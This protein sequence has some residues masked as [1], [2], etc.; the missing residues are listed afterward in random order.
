MIQRHVALSKRRLL[1]P[2]VAGVAVFAGFSLYADVAELRQRLAEFG[3]W[4]FAAALALSACNYGLRWLRWNV[5]LAETD[6]SLPR[7]TSALVFF[8]G[9][10]LS[11]T[12]GKLGEL[13]KCFLVR[14]LAGVA[15]ARTAPIV[16]AER[17]TDLASVLL[18]ALVGRKG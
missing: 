16:V 13:I 7:G 5:Y 11:I 18:L 9:L 3:W 14:R 15:I 10:G 2:I 1:I 4:A 8:S 6:V 12:P 17:V